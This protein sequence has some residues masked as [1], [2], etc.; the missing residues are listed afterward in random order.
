MSSHQRDNVRFMDG[1]DR[2]TTRPAGNRSLKAARL[3]KGYGSQRALADAL[4]TAAIDLGLRGM[5]IGERQIRRWESENPPWPQ[6]H[7]Q[8]VLMGPAFSGQLLNVYLTLR[9]A[10]S[11]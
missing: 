4:N 10:G 11:G 9:A 7:H 1:L 3:A 2:E 5:S 6:A 8:Q